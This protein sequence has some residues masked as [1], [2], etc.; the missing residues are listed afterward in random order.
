MR[1]ILILLT[2]IITINSCTSETE[3]DNKKGDKY[4]N[5]GMYTIRSINDTIIIISPCNS[6]NQLPI[7]IDLK[8]LESIQ[9]TNK[10][11]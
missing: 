2:L 3:S 5:C 10:I 7:V 1:K 4:M 8:N 6:T 11:K 9:G